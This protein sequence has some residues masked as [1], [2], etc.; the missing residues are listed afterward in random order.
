[1]RITALALV[2]SALLASACDSE[3]K[4]PSGSGLAQRTAI[5]GACLRSGRDTATRCACVARAV[6]ATGSELL[7]R[8]VVAQL[9]GN[10]AELER[11]ER[12]M[13]RA[14]F[15]Q[16]MANDSK[17]SRTVMLRCGPKREAS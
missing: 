5:E 8:Y 1:M 11:M 14:E 7:T 6:A 16:L 9:E 15:E 13:S 12:F 2:A 10:Q 17:V 4:K 3:A